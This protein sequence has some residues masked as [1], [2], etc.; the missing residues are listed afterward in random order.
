M[1]KLTPNI[2]RD[3]LIYFRPEREIVGCTRR[4]CSCK[5]GPAEIR[6]SLMTG[7][8]NEHR[9]LRAATR[10]PRALVKPHWIPSTC[11]N[12]F[13]IEMFLRSSF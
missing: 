13:Q 11:I 2:D 8:T 3:T 12:C 10:R 7:I 9:I 5:A 4:L 6:S 1:Y